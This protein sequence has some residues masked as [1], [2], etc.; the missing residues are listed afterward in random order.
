MV[1]IV[2]HFCQVSVNFDRSLACSLPL[3]WSNGNKPAVRRVPKG[4]GLFAKPM[5]THHRILKVLIVFYFKLG[6]E[7]SNPGLKFKLGFKEIMCIWL[8]ETPVK[9]FKPWFKELMCTFSFK[10]RLKFSNLGLKF[11]RRFKQ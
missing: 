7:I 10:P 2:V 11:K 3:S 4:R 8:A 6:F 1:S 5:K 9:N